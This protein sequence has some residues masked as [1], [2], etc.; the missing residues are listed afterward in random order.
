MRSAVFFY[1]TFWSRITCIN[2]CQTTRAEADPNAAAAG[3]EVGTG[4]ICIFSRS[5]IDIAFGSK[6]Y[7]F[8]TDITAFDADIFFSC[9]DVD[10]AVGFYCASLRNSCTAAGFCFWLLAADTDIKAEIT[11]IKSIF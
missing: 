6:T 4:R 9:R 2:A 1:F 10:I 11:S 7:I 8:A 3:F 5:N